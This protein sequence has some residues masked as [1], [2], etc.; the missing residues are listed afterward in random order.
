M[1]YNKNSDRGV[2][3]GE[4][5]A[6]N[7]NHALC[8]AFGEALQMV[9]VNQD[10]FFMEAMKMRSLL[11]ELRSSRIHPRRSPPN[12][13]DYAASSRKELDRSYARNPVVIGLKERIS[14]DEMSISGT[15]VIRADSWFSAFVRRTASL[16]SVPITCASSN[17]WD[18]IY[19]Q[20]RGGVSKA[21]TDLHSMG[22]F[23][24]GTNAALR[25]GKIAFRCPRLLS[26]I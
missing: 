7:Q 1:P 24:G 17:V 19:V 15:F 4:R 22:D 23:F 5:K 3:I 21:T 13:K 18:K 26:F 25:G 6:E 20:T 14:T 12:C 2:I 8:F 9:D 16:S 10:N 11:E